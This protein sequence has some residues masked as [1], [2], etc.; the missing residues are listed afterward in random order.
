MGLT[1][2]SSHGQ[3]W[4]SQQ[5]LA[6]PPCWEATLLPSRCNTPHPPFGMG[7]TPREGGKSHLFAGRQLQ[8]G[9]LPAQQPAAHPGAARV[10]PLRSGPPHPQHPQQHHPPPPPPRSA[11]APLPGAGGAGG[12][13]RPL[14][15]PDTSEPRPRAAPGPAPRLQPGITPGLSD[16]AAPPA[17]RPGSRHRQSREEGP[18]AGGGGGGAGGGGR[19]AA[20]AHAAE[21]GPAPAWR[22]ERGASSGC[23]SP[24]PKPPGRGRQ[25]GAKPAGTAGSPGPAGEPG[26]ISHLGR[27]APIGSGMGAALWDGIPPSPALPWDAGPHPPPSPA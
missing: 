12:D 23:I 19:L 21:A 18:A 2:L 27:L 10:P 25:R 15:L 22:R 3:L 17:A 20:Q 8:G 9:R 11:R 4:G 14:L 16:T 1:L 5:Q 13:H 26:S 7:K 6:T 24:A